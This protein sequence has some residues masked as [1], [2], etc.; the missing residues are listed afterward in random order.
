[1]PSGDS[2]LNVAAG[3]SAMSQ[4][5]TALSSPKAILE[6]SGK[7]VTGWVCSSRSPTY[8]VNWPVSISQKP[9]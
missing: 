7:N 5:Q 6:P 2:A 8:R 4:I 3:F 9:T 1:V